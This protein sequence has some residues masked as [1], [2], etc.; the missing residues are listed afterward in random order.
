MRL[1]PE[2]VVVD[3]EVVEYDG[4]KTGGGDDIKGDWRL[5]YRPRTGVETDNIG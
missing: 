1:V 2:D 3:I 4:D 5:K